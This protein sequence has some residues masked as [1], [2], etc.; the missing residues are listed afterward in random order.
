MGLNGVEIILNSSTSHAELMKLRTRLSLIPNSTKKVGGVYV[1]V[2]TPGVDGKARMM[3]DG[4]SIIVAN[5]KVLEQGAQLSL[6]DVVGVTTATFDIEG[7]Q[8]FRSSIS[9]NV[10]FLFL[11]F[12]RCLIYPQDNILQCSNTLGTMSI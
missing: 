7:V 10:G 8:I 5:G 12:S 3:F 4:S 9:R 1:Y 6:K 11:L 2:N